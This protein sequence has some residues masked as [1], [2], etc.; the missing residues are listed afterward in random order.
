MAEA[1]ENQNV[2]ERL[3]DSMDLERERGITIQ[4]KNGACQYKDYFINEDS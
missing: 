3:M 2:E 1:Q 4:S